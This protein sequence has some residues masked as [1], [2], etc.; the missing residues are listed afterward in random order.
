MIFLNHI[1]LHMGSNLQLVVY[2]YPTSRGPRLNI[3][4]SNNT[5][6]LYAKQRILNNYYNQ[7]A[8]WQK[9]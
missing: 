7:I 5:S 9:R 4:D 2:R 8:L 6:S 1:I 3:I